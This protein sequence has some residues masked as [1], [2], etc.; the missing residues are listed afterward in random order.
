MR[1]LMWWRCL[2]LVLGLAAALRSSPRARSQVSG[3]SAMLARDVPTAVPNVDVRAIRRR[4]EVFAA[5][6]LC[7]EV[8]F[9]AE[10]EPRGG[11]ERWLHDAVRRLA[12]Q[13]LLRQLYGQ[14]SG[15][16]LAALS[17]PQHIML[18]AE[19][20]DAETGLLGFVEMSLSQ[21]LMPVEAASEWGLTPVEDEAPT[22][23]WQVRPGPKYPKY[24]KIQNLAVAEGARGRGI[25]RHLVTRCVAQA[26]QW[27]YRD[28]LLSVEPENVGAVE[29][30]KSLGFRTLFSMPGKK[31]S[32]GGLLS[33]RKVSQ[34]H[35][36][37]HLKIEKQVA[38][39]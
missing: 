26:A 15:A 37:M 12:R 14:L 20:L 34:P 13:R 30:Y 6:A 27:G 28:V 39:D 1:G 19:S 8:F 24:P 36:V 10:E 4:D 31:W 23:A 9:A 29:F 21:S 17:L 5:A 25:G 33:L 32:T 16:M 18:Q 35:L 3:L 11:A 22:R 7:M 2:I 38:E